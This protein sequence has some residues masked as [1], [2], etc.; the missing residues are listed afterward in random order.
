[1]GKTGISGRRREE[2]SWDLGLDFEEWAGRLRKDLKVYREKALSG[3]KRYIPRFTYTAI[4]L[5]QLL[6]ASRISEAV[7]A[8]I[9]Y[10]ET[11]HREYTIQARKK[12]VKRYMYI[13][14][15][16]RHDDIIIMK[17]GFSYHGHNRKRITIST[18]V[19]ANRALGINTHSLRYA[20]ITFYN[21][22]MSTAGVRRITGHT[23]E[24]TVANYIQYRTAR[25]I[26]K[27]V[28]SGELDVRI[29]RRERR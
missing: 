27:A 10:V 3:R 24:E 16:I 6:N 28:T 21:Q 17:T 2:Y 5:T 18:K 4:L 23:K 19:Y 8:V 20:G 26:L 14:T 25:D 22:F 13:P 7:D 15:D 12:G 11:S 9:Y 1:M 29:R